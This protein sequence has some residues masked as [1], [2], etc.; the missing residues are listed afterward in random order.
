METVT[1][2]GGESLVKSKKASPFK[3]SLSGILM[4]SSF[5]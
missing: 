1:I 2:K 5:Y 4:I 3:E